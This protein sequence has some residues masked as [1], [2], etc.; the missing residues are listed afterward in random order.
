MVYTD[1]VKSIVVQFD[2]NNFL[3][4]TQFSRLTVHDLEMGK[5]LLTSEQITKPCAIEIFEIDGKIVTLSKNIT[6]KCF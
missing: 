2:K 4:V 3:V 5:G 1:L 6:S